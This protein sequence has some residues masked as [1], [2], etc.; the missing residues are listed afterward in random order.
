MPDSQAIS[1][2]QMLRPRMLVT[3]RYRTVPPFPLDRADTEYYY[4][5][6]NGV[7]ALARAW[8]LAGQE[9]LVP[10]YCHGVEMAALLHAGAD[11]L[12]IFPIYASM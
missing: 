7:F 12:I 8:G 11:C 2:F 6:R 1:A 9:V 3:R 10:A 5:A 4:L